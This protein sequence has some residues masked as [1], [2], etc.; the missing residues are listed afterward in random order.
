MARLVELTSE[1]TVYKRQTRLSASASESCKDH[2]ATD[3]GSRPD[4][5][6]GK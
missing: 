2:S 3:F 6:E 5:L 4:P 1:P